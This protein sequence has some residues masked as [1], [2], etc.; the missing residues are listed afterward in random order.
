MSDW[1]AQAGAVRRNLGTKSADYG[2][3]FASGVY[4]FGLNSSVTLEGQ[5]EASESVRGAGLGVSAAI[6]GQVL[7]QAAIAASE[8]ESGDAG[9]TWILGAEHLSL[10]HGFTLHS[11]AST[12]DYRRIGQTDSFPT[13]DRQ[14]LARYT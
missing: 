11:E 10:R 6:F 7:G 1:T 5:A 4:R 14:L 12:R 2:E 13:Y 9:A 3:A 8:N